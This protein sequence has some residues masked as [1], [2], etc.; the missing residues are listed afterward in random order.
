MKN[1]YIGLITYG[2]FCST[3]VTAQQTSFV[4]KPDDASG[5]VGTLYT[6]TEVSG[7]YS[8]VCHEGQ[9]GT[10]VKVCFSVF[11]TT[12]RDNHDW[13]FCNLHV[14]VEA[15]G[16]NRL[17]KVI[18]SFKA[19]ETILSVP[20]EPIDIDQFEKD[21]KFSMSAFAIVAAASDN[22]PSIYGK[23]NYKALFNAKQLEVTYTLV[24]SEPTT[25]TLPTQGLLVTLKRLMGN[26]HF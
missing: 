26:C 6:N 19:D 13:F 22:D 16:A 25:I 23:K 8:Y 12:N 3:T 10:D 4:Y 2:L 14:G 24:G 5:W 18:P 20:Y 7:Q 21:G 11:G 9:N 17:Q 1:T 15:S